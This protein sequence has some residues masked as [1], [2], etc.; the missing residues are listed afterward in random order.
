[1]PLLLLVVFLL[2]H[3]RLLLPTLLLLLLLLLLPQAHH[4]LLQLARLA[5]G[6]RLVLRWAAGRVARWQTR[7][8]APPTPAPLGRGCLTSSEAAAGAG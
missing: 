4:P 1:M 5:V 6:R 3:L 7:Q 2:L 8:S